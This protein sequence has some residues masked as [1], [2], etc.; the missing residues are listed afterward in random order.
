MRRV[1]YPFWEWE[2]VGMW[3]DVSM[4]EYAD[5]LPRAVSFTGDAERYGAAMLQVVEAFPVACE[6]NL[7]EPAINKR[8]WIGHAAVFLSFGCPEWITRE[9]WS[10]LTEEQCVAADAKADEA[11]KEWQKRYAEKAR[12]LHPQ[13]AIEGLS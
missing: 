1:Y 11:I 6:H 9:A 4:P 8:A 12:G 5:L 7:T 3:R 13:M 2:D 10:M